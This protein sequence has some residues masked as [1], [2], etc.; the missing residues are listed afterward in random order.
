MLINCDLSYYALFNN[1]W[2]K[3]RCWVGACQGERLVL[4]SP[5]PV[6]DPLEI[7]VKYLPDSMCF[8]TPIWRRW[9]NQQIQSRDTLALVCG[10][11]KTRAI[12]QEYSV[13][14]G[15]AF[16]RWRALTGGRA[17]VNDCEKAS[18][19]TR[20]CDCMDAS[21]QVRVL[22]FLEFKPERNSS[23]IL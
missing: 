5:P 2:L 23:P 11:T 19:H 3:E 17:L 21:C 12:E 9:C 16:H 8:M 14:L 6:T 13:L 20:K 15:S 10:G 22:I 1:W 4:Y 18:S 7:D